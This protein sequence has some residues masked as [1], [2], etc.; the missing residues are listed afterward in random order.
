MRG[1]CQAL[2]TQLAHKLNHIKYRYFLSNL[3]GYLVGRKAW[4][5]GVVRKLITREDLDS[6]VWWFIEYLDFGQC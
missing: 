1:P 6:V 5:M 3:K 2:L 4:F